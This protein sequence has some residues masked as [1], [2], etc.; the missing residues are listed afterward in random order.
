MREVQVAIVGAGAAGIGV[1]AETT[2]H[3]I[4][5]VLIDNKQNVGGQFYARP[6]RRG[7]LDGLSSHL[8]DGIDEHLLTLE[9]DTE[10]WGAFPGRMLALVTEDRC[11]FMRARTIV[12]ATGAIERAQP[13]PG[14]EQPGV[15]S[16]GA[17][18]LLLK[19]Q[20]AV[21][22]GAVV[23]AGTGPFLFAVAAQ[24]LEAGVNVQTIVEALPM[25]RLMRIAPAFIRDTE[26]LLESIAYARQTVS[27]RRIFGASIVRVDNHQVRLSNGDVLRFD[28]LCVGHGFRPRLGLPMMF[29]CR[30][31]DDAVDVDDNFQTSVSGVYAAGEATGIGGATLAHAEGRLAGLGIVQNLGLSRNDTAS[32]VAAARRAQRRLM[33]FSRALAAVYRPISPLQL[34]TGDTLICRCEGVTLGEI[35][36]SARDDAAA[37]PRGAKAA[38]R[39]GMGPCQGSMCEEAIRAVFSGDTAPLDEPRSRPP[40]TPVSVGSIAQLDV[41]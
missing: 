24:L 19:E 35:R 4:P 18:Q 28:T 33:R 20:D 29:G 3:G 41:G 12:L 14:W 1:A 25:R 30:I 36:A 16:A 11:E 34:A 27:A 13:F 21:L 10:V 38:L 40:L 2:R 26:R 23:V 7:P 17:A 39:C 22:N 9:T 32:R 15:I 31:T 6:R 37:N 8:L 5:T